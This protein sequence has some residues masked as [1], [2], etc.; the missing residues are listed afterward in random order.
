MKKLNLKDGIYGV[1]GGQYNRVCYK[2]FPTYLGAKRYANANK[3]YWD[4][5][6]GWHTPQV[7]RF[8]LEDLAEAY[9]T[10]SGEIVLN[11]EY[12]FDQWVWDL[13]QFGLDPLNDQEVEKI[14][15]AIN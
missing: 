6:Q 13:E 14:I 1:I 3:E 4:N 15:N 11:Y 10:K 5:W 12:T 8:S 7:V 2:A 9:E